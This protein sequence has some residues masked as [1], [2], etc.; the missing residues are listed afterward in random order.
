MTRPQIKTYY[1]ATEQR[2]I[3]SDLEYAVSIATNTKVAIDC[4]CGAGAD[5]AFLLDNGFRVHGF[6]IEEGSISRC[7]KRFKNNENV[8]LYNEG[9]D[10]F[11]YPAASLVVADASLFFCAADQFE[12]VWDRIYRCLDDG[13]VFA[14]SFLGLDDSMARDDYNKE[15]IWP[16]VLAF[17]EQQVRK[18]F[19]KFE[20]MRFTEHKTSGVNVQGNN[21]DWHIYSIVAKK[22]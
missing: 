19:S 11:N 15:D 21:H 1:D 9:F 13:G 16:D 4:G 20:I 14:G 2:E 6:D 22:K 18:H 8:F 7:E 12:T 10:T 5:I 3:R 17:N